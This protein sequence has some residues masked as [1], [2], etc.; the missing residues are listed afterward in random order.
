MYI[1]YIKSFYNNK[2]CIKK[3][4]YLYILI[5][6]MCNLTLI[7][8]SYIKMQIG[9]ITNQ[10]E[11]RIIN[12]ELK[13]DLNVKS[14]IKKI[15][16]M[17]KIQFV[18]YYLFNNFDDKIIDFDKIEPLININEDYII[19]VP[20]ELANNINLD[21]ENVKIYYVN[22]NKIS[23][24]LSLALHLNQIYNLNNFNI[25]FIAKSYNYVNEIINELNE[26]G[27]SAYYNPSNKLELDTYIKLYKIINFIIFFGFLLATIIFSISILIMIYEQKKDIYLLHILGYKN[28]QLLNLIIFENFIFLF[29]SSIFNF[30][31]LLI[32]KILKKIFF[33]KA[34]LVIEFKNIFIICFIYLVLIFIIGY[35]VFALLKRKEF[36][37]NWKF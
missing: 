15:K 37:I 11:N 10:E 31:I 33:D 22:D 7:V 6:L 21:T 27:F 18:E 28:N 29:I 19:Y 4:I 35:I 26:F 34:L 24:N 14:F 12:L 23:F 17:S 5:I 36:N 16:N 3:Y 8:N 2:K 25:K 20:F 9:E 1:E 32:V 30:I 13:D